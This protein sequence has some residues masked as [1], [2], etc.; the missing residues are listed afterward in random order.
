MPT[1]NFTAAQRNTLVELLCACPAMADTSTREAVIAQLPE[2]VRHGITRHPAT[3]VDVMNIVRRC[4]DYADGPAALLQAVAF[5]E[6]DSLPMQAVHAWLQA[7]Q[8]TPPH[9]HPAAV[10]D[11]DPTALRQELARMRD[12]L[13]LIQERMGQ[14]VLSTEVPLQLV[15]EERRYQEAIRE[16][17]QRLAAA[18][19][20]TPL[21]PS[22]PPAP[23]P[24]APN[25]FGRRGRI[26]D[27]VEFFDREDLLRQIFAELG[28]GSS[29]ALVGP[30]EAVI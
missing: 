29:L 4:L 13:R 23:N 30:R 3:K 6:G 1:P 10:P 9:P 27:P 19:P 22:N 16:L 11:V 26:D 24:P 14:F 21:T 8:S 18:Q 5:F 20:P 28:K 2:Q 7:E 15:K 25:P 12:H 17:E